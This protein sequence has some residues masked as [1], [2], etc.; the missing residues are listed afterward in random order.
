MLLRVGSLAAGSNNMPRPGMKGR[1]WKGRHDL[2]TLDRNDGT[3]VE[4]KHGMHLI[5]MMVDGRHGMH[6]HEGIVQICTRGKKGTVCMHLKG[7]MVEGS[8]FFAMLR[9]AHS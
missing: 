2:H 4:G 6:A 1:W 5:G 8:A 3:T 7:M 9:D